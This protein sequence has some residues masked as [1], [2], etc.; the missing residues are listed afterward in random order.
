[1]FDIKKKIIVPDVLKD[2]QHR[3]GRI[4]LSDG[5]LANF[6][7]NR[8]TSNAI[9]N[10][11]N[12]KES[13]EKINDIIFFDDSF[14]NVPFS[15]KGTGP[16]IK[17]SEK[18][19]PYFQVFQPE[20]YSSS[21]VKRFNSRSLL[22]EKDKKSI[23]SLTVENSDIE[24]S[25][26]ELSG[27]VI[28]LQSSDGTS[29]NYRPIKTRFFETQSNLEL[30]LHK[31]SIGELTEVQDTQNRVHAAFSL[32]DNEDYTQKFLIDGSVTFLDNPTGN[33]IYVH[34][35]SIFILNVAVV[36]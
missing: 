12:K 4:N 28:N 20:Q 35:D 9:A 13:N 17:D 32:T 23:G 24:V 7:F 22:L 27:S 34:N 31:N 21:L 3:S 26:I 1:M 16:F 25:N 11:S 19:I 36:K 14:D 29:I 18:N 5:V 6:V 33:N 8:T 15:L 10:R 30:F 2:I